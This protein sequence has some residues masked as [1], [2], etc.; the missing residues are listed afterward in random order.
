M[1]RSGWFGIALAL[2]GREA[3]AQT[4]YPMITRAQPCALQRGKTAEVTIIGN[5][6][7]SGASGLLF[8]GSGLSGQVLD[9]GTGPKPDAKG[10]TRATASVRVQLSA[11]ADTAL[12]P[13]ELR[14]VTPQGVSS[15]GMIMV[16]PDPVAV[17]ADDK[18]NDLPDHAQVLNLPVALVGTIGKVEDVDWYSVSVQAGQ[19]VTFSLWGNRLEN[20]IHDLQ[21]HLDPIIL[22][23]DAQGREL[24]ANDNHD[25]ADPMLSYEFKD[26]GTY[27]VEVRD[28]TYAG[29]ANWTYVLQA[30]SG[31]YVTAAFPMAINPGKQ[32]ELHAAGFNFDATQSITLKVPSDARPGPCDLVLP[33]KEGASLPFPLV[34]TELPLTVEADDTA[35]EGE[36]AQSI[37]M[38]VAV[39]GRLREANDVDGYRFEAK[40]GTTY[41]FEVVAR[42]AGA[43]TD[44]VLRVM[45]AKGQ[46][47]AEADDTFGKDPRLEWTA[48]EDGAFLLQLNDLHSRGG[49][50]F[51][52]VLQAEPAHADFVLTCDPDKASIGPGA[53]T[54]VFAKV[55]RRG[56]FT[57]PV[58]LEWNNLPAGMSASA[59]TIPPQMTQGVVVLTA[60]EAATPAA[61]LIM[62]TGKGGT[63][64]G[65]IL[66]PA[67]PK[68]EIYLPGGG[69]GLYRVSTMAAAVTNPSDITVEAQPSEVIL[70]PGGTVTIDVKITRQEGFTKGVNLAVNLSHLGGVFGSPLPKGVSVKEAES[71]TLLSPKETAGKIVLEAMPDAPAIERVPMTVM[72]HVSIDFVVKTAYCSSP[73]ALTVAPEGVDRAGK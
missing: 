41:A 69:R 35:A 3:A 36:R 56:G 10:R 52:Y 8:E 1:R 61:S 65:T 24:A 15:I 26:A 40:K 43:A 37:N 29:N 22:L 44:P 6:D 7:F 54:A 47:L 71:K 64:Q 27:L 45:N 17:E 38:P 21:Q 60:A 53:R 2:L 68:E 70:R 66:R 51:G 4:S 13:R 23:H 55:E 50:G 46:S 5:H 58:T 14:V 28:T 42:R 33:M 63:P 49:E 48:P 11:A 67:S 39:S 9:A 73:I 57:G 72:G 20:K 30:T 19:R 32:A 18:A 16:V 25:F 59:L 12:G 31:P 62:V 34:V